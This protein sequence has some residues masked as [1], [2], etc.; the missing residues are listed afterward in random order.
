MAAPI[1]HNAQTGFSNST[2][3]D[4]H[5]PSY[6]PTIVEFLLTQ[7]HVCGKKNAKILDL[8]AGTGKF[9]EALASREEEFEIVAVEPHEQ[10][11]GTLEAKG[12]RGV[13]VLDGKGDSIPLENASVD[14]VICAQVGRHFPLFS[15]S[16]YDVSFRLS[17][18][19]T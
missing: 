19:C 10:M 1:S 4:S 17:V 16:I 15:C 5:R 18:W 11:R 8:A 9:T 13:R 2:A 7:L 14:A 3:Y 12:L 6:S